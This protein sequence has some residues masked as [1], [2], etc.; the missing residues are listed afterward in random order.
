VPPFAAYHRSRV[1][2]VCAALAAESV[3]SML[4]KAAQAAREVPFLEF[5]LDSLPDPLNAL[6]VIAPFLAANSPITALATCRRK[7]NGGGFGGSEDHQLRVLCAAAQAGFHLVDVEIETAESVKQEALVPLRESGAA[8]VLSWHDFK[9]TPDLN[10]VFRR[11]KPFAPDYYKLVP[12]AQTL[13]DNLKLL[14]FVADASDTSS[15][16]GICM[17]EA[18]VLSRVLGLRAG[19]AFTFA[20]AVP[21]EATGPGQFAARTLLETFRIDDVDASTKVFGV[22]GDPVS[23]SLSPVMLNAAFRRETVN[24]LYVPLPTPDVTD[25]VTAIR[26]IPLAGVSITM[27]H[28]QTIL[29]HLDHVDPLTAKIGA[30]NT[31]LRVVGTKGAPAQLY[32]FN[33]DVS[34]IV[35]PL[36]KRMTLRGARVLVL[37]AG[38]AARAAVFGLVDQGAEVHIL[39]RTPERA[40]ALAREA[41]AKVAKPE[42]LVRTPWSAIVN[43]TSVGMAGQPENVL[44]GP[45]DF[46]RGL[47]AKFV[48][49]LVYNPLETPLLRAAK[50]AGI[51]T[52]PGIEMFVHQGARQFELWTGKPAPV[53]EMQRVVLH[54]LRQREDAAGAPTATS[55]QT[56]SKSLPLAAPPLKQSTRASPKPSASAAKE[57]PPAK[58]AAPKPPGK[59]VHAA[60]AKAPRAR[61]K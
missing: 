57:V 29:K 25:L 60:P 27:P 45:A 58:K 2:K 50:D 37:G 31:I 15:V 36:E 40:A 22:A 33:T 42:T 12:T 35:V 55:T 13:T 19:A 38:G 17:G 11:M 21:G 56:Q 26:E 24:A 30:C 14:R 48:F 54:A 3:A 6:K 61:A 10:A 18:G 44:L 47:T 41:K 16:V 49:D 32:G 8:L 51:A 9:R 52:I 28:K 1:G 5:R 23:K 46:A 53:D 34:G 7:P 20:A 43:A 59:P 39:N 4:Q